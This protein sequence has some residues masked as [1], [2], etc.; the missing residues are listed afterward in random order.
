MSNHLVENNYRRI[1]TVR[2]S[3]VSVINKAE[4]YHKTGDAKAAYDLKRG[5]TRLHDE[6]K[7]R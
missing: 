5:V 3:V 4:Y 6:G 1:E 2:K 7:E